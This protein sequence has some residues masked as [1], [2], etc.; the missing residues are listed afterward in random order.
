MG[1]FSVSAHV[2]EV[3]HQQEKN[4]FSACSLSQKAFQT[5]QVREDADGRLMCHDCA[6]EAWPYQCT[7]CKRREPASE[8]KDGRHALEAA[9]N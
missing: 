4:A 1:Y 3:C 8:F 2:C 9:Y 5:H 7:V 6:P